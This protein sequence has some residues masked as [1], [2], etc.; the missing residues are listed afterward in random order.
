[1]GKQA[2]S[3][4]MPQPFPSSFSRHHAAAPFATGCPLARGSVH[5][6]VLGGDML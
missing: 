1:M 5:V 3:L 2:F 4:V 6:G